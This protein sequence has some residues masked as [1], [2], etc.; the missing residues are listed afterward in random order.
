VLFLSGGVARRRRAFRA[1]VAR[2]ALWAVLSWLLPPPKARPSRGT[3]RRRF[4]ATPTSQL[5][6]FPR[7]Q[8]NP[9][10]AKP[11]NQVTFAKWFRS[12]VDSL[13]E[14]IGRGGEP[15]DR[16]GLTPYSFRHSYAQRHVVSKIVFADTFAESVIGAAQRLSCPRL[17]PGS[18]LTSRVAGRCH[19]VASSD[20]ATDSTLM[21]PVAT[22]RGG[23]LASSPSAQPS[24]IGVFT[25]LEQCSLPVPTVAP[26]SRSW[27]F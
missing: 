3:S 26:P 5:G 10:G 7:F 17:L 22:Q 20:V 9:R 24:A 21:Q 4:P 25:C 6:L 2:P 1:R 18:L 15:Y 23:N 16:S 27:P 13:P 11:Y 8:K 14:I 12:W 19:D